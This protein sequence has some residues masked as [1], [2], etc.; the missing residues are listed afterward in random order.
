MNLCCYS[1][2]WKPRY[3]SDGKHDRFKYKTAG[4]TAGEYEM[5]S[6]STG[7]GRSDSCGSAVWVE[8]SH[9]R[10]WSSMCTAYEQAAIQQL[11]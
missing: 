11:K 3:E 7:N 9:V 4:G 10:I 6:T 2:G 1:Q 5:A 8:M